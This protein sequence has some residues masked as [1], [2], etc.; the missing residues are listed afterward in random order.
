L[1][2]IFAKEKEKYV[3]SE[4][5]KLQTFAVPKMIADYLSAPSKQEGERQLKFF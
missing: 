1:N 3:L 4:P 5:K 2:S